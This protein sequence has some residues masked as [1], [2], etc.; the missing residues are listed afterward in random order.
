LVISH[1]DY[2]CYWS[3]I[4]RICLAPSKIIVEHVQEDGEIITLS[5]LVRDLQKAFF[6]DVGESFMV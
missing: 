4:I 1:G 3:I 6:V 5:D 2:S